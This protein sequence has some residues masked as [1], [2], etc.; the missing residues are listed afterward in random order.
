[1]ATWPLSSKRLQNGEQI[2]MS[3][4]PLAF[5]WSPQWGGTK[6]ATYPVCL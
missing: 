5:L 1:M 3:K 2:N 4:K 6:M